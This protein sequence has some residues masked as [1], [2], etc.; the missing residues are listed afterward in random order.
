MA[1]IYFTIQIILIIVIIAGA[2]QF[3]NI[4]FRGHAPFIKTRNKILKAIIKEINL[5]KKD[6]VYE[7]GSGNASILRQ[8][9]KKYPHNKFIG[10]EYALLPWLISKIQASLTNSEIIIKKQNFFKA[11]LSQANYIYCFLNIET[12]EKL[13]KKLK[14]ECKKGCIVISY[15]FQLP[16]IKPYQ[17]IEIKKN[18]I[19]FYKI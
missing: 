18:H 4:L 17:V 5:N 12:M 11:D 13:E 8:L 15:V 6:I 1:I 7:L 19:Y 2:I 9:E 3:F 10:I 14:K 16:H